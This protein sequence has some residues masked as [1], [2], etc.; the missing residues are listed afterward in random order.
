MVEN[1][2]LRRCAIRAVKHDF[3]MFTRG[4]TSPNETVNMVIP[5]LMSFYSLV[6]NWSVASRIKPHKGVCHPTKCHII[7]DVK[8]F[9]TVY[10]S[11]L[12]QLFYII[13]SDVALQKQ[14]H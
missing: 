9:L 8:L 14:V 2:V 10:H 13:Q 12:S 11:I 6:S 5:I 7:N 3:P 1:L 4:Y